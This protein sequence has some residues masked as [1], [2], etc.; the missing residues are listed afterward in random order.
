MQGQGG[1]WNFPKNGANNE[2]TREST[3]VNERSD[4]ATFAWPPGSKRI[5]FAVITLMIVI[6]F[7][8][9]ERFIV[10][11]TDP[12]WTYYYPIRWLLVPHG[13]AGAAPLF[14]GL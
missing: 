12:S 7:Y 2:L 8:N 9:N 1:C 10:D 13:I 11:H 3:M 4:P 5:L 14:F 6:V